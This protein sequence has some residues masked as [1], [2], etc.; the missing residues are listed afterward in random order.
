MTLVHSWYSIAGGALALG[1]RPG[2][3][4]LPALRAAT[5]V[6]TL[7]SEKEGALEL[8]VQLEAMGLRWWH[9]ALTNGQPFGAERDA[10]VLAV[11]APLVQRLR[12]GAKL[13]VHCAAGIHRTGM[14]GAALLY[15]LGLDDAQ[16]SA[17]LAQL[18]PVTAEG[19]GADRLAVARR[20]AVK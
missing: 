14:I 1:P 19:V 2:K 4:T 16:V 6:L 17:A 18:R 8:K 7:L 13:Y 12:D 11:L 3:R 9:L 5:D 20:F 10:E 15:S